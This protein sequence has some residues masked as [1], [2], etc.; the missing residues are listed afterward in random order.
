MM[1]GPDFHAGDYRDKQ[2]TPAQNAT[3][4]GAYNISRPAEN[5]GANQRCEQDHLIA[6]ELAGPMI[7]QYPAGMLSRLCRLECS[8]VSG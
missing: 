5:T 1:C 7:F 6:V 4:Y 2:S 8:G 3:T